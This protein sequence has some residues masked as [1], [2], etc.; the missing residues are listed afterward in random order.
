[1]RIY[2]Q[3]NDRFNGGDVSII[4]IFIVLFS[5]LLTPAVTYAAQCTGSGTG[6][7]DVYVDTDASCGGNAG[8]SADPYCS[9]AEGEAAE[10]SDVVSNGWDAV[11]FHMKGSSSAADTTCLFN[12]WTA[13]ASN[14]IIVQT[15][16]SGAWEDRNK[17]GTYSDDYYRIEY[18]T[19]GNAQYGI[20]TVESYTYIFGLQVH[21][22]SDDNN[23]YGIYAVSCAGTFD[24]GYNI[25]KATLTGGSTN[26]IGIYFN[27][28]SDTTHSAYNNVIYDWVNSTN[29]NRGT[30]CASGSNCFWYN[31]TV[32]NCR[33]GIVDLSGGNDAEVWN[34][35]V[36]NATSGDTYVTTTTFGDGGYNASDVDE[37]HMP[38]YGSSCD[39]TSRCDLS[40]TD[41]DDFTEPS[42]DDYSVYDTSS[43]LEDGGTDSPNSVTWTD[44][45]T[46]YTRT[47]DWDIGA[48]E[49]QSGGTTTTT[50]TSTTSTSTTT[51]ATTTTTTSVPTTTTTSTST[52]TTSTSTTTTTT[53]TSTTTTTTSTT[54]TSTTTTT[55]STS[56]TTTSTTT[57]VATTTTTLP[58]RIILVR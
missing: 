8:S 35:A 25:V 44:D 28:G 12:G 9:C 4:R 33:Q 45:L 21:V 47:T 52:T 24:A 27:C 18:T 29:L 43:I 34:C 20:A 46:G 50:S 5:L 11:I 26:S 53:S 3:Q 13:G 55:T 49:Y 23:A 14:V 40:D 51:P 56:S 58:F 17:T 16:D 54:S 1:M 6:D 7:C 41:A 10:Q 2:Q 42:T 36:M 39:G 57:G 31:E 48:Y 22:T 19:T 37:A 32:D 38:G 15:D 30:A